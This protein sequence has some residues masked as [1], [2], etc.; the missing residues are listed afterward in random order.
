[1]IL[2]A[3]GTGRLGTLLVR[4]LVKRGLTVR[5]MTRAPDRARHLAAAHVDIVRGD[6]RDRGTLDGA[7]MDG[8]RTVVSAVHGFAGPDRVSP[9]SI[10]VR[11]NINLIDAASRV[12]ADVVMVSVVGAARDSPMELSRAKYQ[13]EQYLR[14]TGVPWTIIRATAFVETWAM[15]MGDPLRTTGRLMVFG[16]GSNPINFVSAIDVAALIEHAVLEPTLRGRTIELGGTR[17]VTFNEFAKLLDQ[18]IG[19]HAAVRHVPRPVL[20]LMGALLGPV[21]P[22]LARQA[23]AAVAIDTAN[24][25]FDSTATRGEFPDLPN[26]ELATALEQYFAGSHRQPLPNPI[27][28]DRPAVF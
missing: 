20:R 19:G 1:M 21:N 18:V 22:Q 25:R 24:M 13:A 12:R 11:G 3:G 15:V 28:R 5:V 2:I 14:S 8:V 23:R 4:R 10:D 26:T 6:V 27:P 7:V 17:D 16:R 9:A